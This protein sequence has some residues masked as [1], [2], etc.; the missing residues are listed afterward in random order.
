MHAG[1][2]D[3]EAAIV[4]ALCVVQA[5]EYHTTA[6]RPPGIATLTDSPRFS[7][8]YLVEAILSFSPIAEHGGMIAVTTKDNH[9]IQSICQRSVQPSAHASL[10]PNHDTLTYWLPGTNA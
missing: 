4:S 9:V 2:K 6:Q 3:V 7:A 10:Q 1:N 5:T 8:L